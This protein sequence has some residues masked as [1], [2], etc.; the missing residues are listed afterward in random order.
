[1]MWGLLDGHG[2]KSLSCGFF[3]FSLMITDNLFFFPEMFIDIISILFNILSLF[4]F[5]NIN[6]KIY[7]TFS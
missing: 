3:V 6:F 2:R 5:Y 1:M 4:V 7:E